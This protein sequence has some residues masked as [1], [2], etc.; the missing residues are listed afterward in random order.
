MAVLGC[1]LYTAA[2][3]LSLFVF[4]CFFSRSVVADLIFGSLIGLNWVSFPVT[5]F[6]FFSRFSERLLLY[7]P[8]RY[9]GHLMALVQPERNATDKYNVPVEVACL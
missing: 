6:D 5:I 3:S 7:P 4:C 9:W 1:S 8:Q 2:Y